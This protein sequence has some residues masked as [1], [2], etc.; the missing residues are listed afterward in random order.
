MD[1]IVD[2][3]EVDSVDDSESEG[4]I[5]SFTKYPSISANFTDMHAIIELKVE[6]NKPLE[7]V[8]WV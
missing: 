3:C 1:F 5:N 8:Q 2:E 4:R 6:R 7:M